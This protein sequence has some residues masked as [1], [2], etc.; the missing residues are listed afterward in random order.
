MKE[1]TEQSVNNL[2]PNTRE[3]QVSRQRQTY[4]EPTGWTTCIN[5][6]TGGLLVRVQPEEPIFSISYRRLLM[7]GFFGVHFFVPPPT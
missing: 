3:H 4:E 2:F 5:L 1:G 7:R 6:L